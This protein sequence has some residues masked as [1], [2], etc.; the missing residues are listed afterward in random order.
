MYCANGEIRIYRK[1]GVVG[2][3]FVFKSPI[4]F[5]LIV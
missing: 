2:F 5:K 3:Y 4:F 1:N